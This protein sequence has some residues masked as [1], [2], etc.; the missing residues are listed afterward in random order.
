MIAAVGDVLVPTL[1]VEM[2]RVAGGLPAID[3]KVGS[4]GI[5]EI[6]LGDIRIPTQDNGETW[7]HFTKSLPERYISAADVLA[8]HVNPAM[9][10]SKL[11]LI[12]LTG[13][14]IAGLSHHAS[15]RTSAGNRGPCPITG[16]YIRW[17]LLAAPFLDACA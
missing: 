17:Q 2:L 9:I 5:T 11:V 14:R 16:E 7:V 13:L 1:S 3:V 10:E 12:G 8:G 4:R 15:R 6:D